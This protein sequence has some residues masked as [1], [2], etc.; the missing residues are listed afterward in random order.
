MKQ[1]QINTNRDLQSKEQSRKIATASSF[2]GIIT[3]T[4]NNSLDNRNTN[5]PSVLG[6][7][8]MNRT[9]S[10][11]DSFDKLTI[12]DQIPRNQLKNGKSCENLWMKTM[13]PN[14]S[15]L[16]SFEKYDSTNFI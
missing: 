10:N 6:K 13:A 2:G 3:N 15:Q 12:N 7:M 9:T 14:S 11:S 4:V 1:R 8:A 16:N 5:L